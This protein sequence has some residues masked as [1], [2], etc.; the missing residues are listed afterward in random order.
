MEKERINHPSHYNR[1]GRKECIVEMEERPDMGRLGVYFFDKGNAFKYAYRAGAKD[2]NPEEDDA[3]KIG[4]Y[5]RHRAKVWK[6]WTPFQRWFAQLA[7]W[8]CR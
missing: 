6:S 5:D 3:R 2:G 4:W 7:V 8:V 1:E